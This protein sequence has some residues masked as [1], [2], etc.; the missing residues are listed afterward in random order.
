MADAA[1]RVD[2]SGYSEMSERLR[3]AGKWIG[4]PG[5]WMGEC[6]LALR[7]TLAAQGLPADL[8]ADLED[9]LAAIRIGFQRAG[10]STSF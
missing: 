1:D 10:Q 3:V 5:E 2:A 6:G 7:D 4:T 9:A 8:R